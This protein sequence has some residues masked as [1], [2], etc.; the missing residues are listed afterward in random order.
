[1]PRRSSRL[2]AKKKVNYN[3]DSYFDR[4]LG[5]VKSGWQKT[6]SR[7]QAKPVNRRKIPKPPA[8]FQKKQFFRRKAP[9]AR[10]RVPK[11][12]VRVRKK[13]KTK[14]EKEIEVID[15]TGDSPELRMEKIRD[16]KVFK[17]LSQVVHARPSR[18]STSTCY[19]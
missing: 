2:A 8:S 18:G 1:M 5:S 4:V 11:E 12:I 6:V 19:L 14:F 10:P 16:R 15:L 13:V 7:L 3:V 17:P 9:K